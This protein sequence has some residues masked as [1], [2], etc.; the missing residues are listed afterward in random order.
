MLCVAVAAYIFMLCV[1]VA[2]YILILCSFGCIIRNIVHVV[3]DRVESV[4]R[5]D[6]ATEESN[7]SST[8]DPED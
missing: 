5:K 2:A 1:P 6:A 7:D 8:V 4:H 3:Y